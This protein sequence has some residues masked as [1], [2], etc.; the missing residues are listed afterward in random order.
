MPA[1]AH[2]SMPN[3]G[4]RAD[5]DG[6]RAVAV[7]PVVFYHAGFETFSG[8][9]V[10]VDVFFVISGFLITS[11]LASEI[12][13]G[14]F[15]LRSFYIRRA[16]RLF[17][18]LFAVLAASSIAA[19]G[20]LMPWELED[21]GKSVSTTALFSSNFL[22]FSEAG[23]FD[24]PAELKPLLHTW[25]LAIEEQY[26]LLFP[27]F[28]LLIHKRLRSHFMAWT[29]GV[30]VLSFVISLW[31]VA[32]GPDAAFYLLP[33]R[34]WELLVGSLLALAPV[35][36][37]PEA[38]REL[39]GLA[40]LALIFVAVFSFDAQTM[41]PGAAALLPCLGAGLIIACG[42]EGESTMTMKILELRAVVFFGLI[43][44]SLYLWH[45]PILV[46]AKHY[47]LTPLSLTQVWV[48]VTVAVAVAI[49]SWHFIEKP[50]RGKKGKL[51]GTGVLRGSM[52]LMLAAIVVGVVYDQTDGLP[53]RLPDN[54]GA[55]AAVSDDK[56]RE[57]KRCEGIAPEEL[58]FERV[59]RV[60]DIEEPPSFAVW[61]DSHAMAAMPTIGRVAA[62][63]N[64]NGLN[65]TSNGCTPLL[66][67]WRPARDA[68][69][70]C[71][72]FNEA[73]LDLIRRHPEIDTIIFVSRWARHVHGT[74]FGNEDAANMFF[75]DA[76]TSASTPTENRRIFSDAL[77][78]TL[79]QLLTLDRRIVII[80]PVPETGNDIPNVL[81]KS[82]WRGRS[83]DLTVP[84]ELFDA[85]QEHVSEIFRAAHKKSSFEYFA[86]HDYF[87]DERVCEVTN[88]DG[89]PLYFDDNHISS[90]GGQRLVPLFRH[91]LSQEAFDED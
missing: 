85:R 56:P 17:P 89:L 73:S 43:S 58:S 82:V 37:L 54:V 29:G 7:L 62:E 16:R 31:S 72:A 81:A 63:T 8:G 25:S 70:E 65:I 15:A 14:Q 84:R 86:A 9:F 22:F 79:V 18:A 23:Y 53:G 47:F 59:C 52:A 68:Q 13:S 57:R 51:T 83:L 61:G 21:F 55:I 27:G 74:V 88:D 45:W 40:G 30:F 41:F 5:I 78:E 4:Y 42:R 80:G 39:A 19:F 71:V 11:I 12:R 44:Y 67:L 87:C 75:A 28:L 33:S 35:P 64:V 48:L 91:I 60:N 20:L 34:A 32:N 69:R 6:L 24:G 36:R 66:G 1:S 2:S 90:H 49:F 38:V 10:G 26:Y 46:F 77:Q 76:Q 3:L 50:F